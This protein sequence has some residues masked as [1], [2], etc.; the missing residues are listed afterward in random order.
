VLEVPVE[1]ADAKS[2]VQCEADFTRRAYRFQRI[3]PSTPGRAAWLFYPEQPCLRSWADPHRVRREIPPIL[4]VVGGD[5]RGNPRG[6]V[7]ALHT[8]GGSWME[9]L[10]E[11]L[12]RLDVVQHGAPGIAAGAPLP[13][14]QDGEQ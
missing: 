5:H 8:S 7:L 2:T 13:V 6:D 14:R 11:H 1:G 4:Q 12:E 3:D 10:H 9:H